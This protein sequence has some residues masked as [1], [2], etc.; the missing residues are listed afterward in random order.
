MIKK[1]TWTPVVLTMLVGIAIS[2]I[3]FL[4]LKKTN[5]RDL[6]QKFANASMERANVIIE[7]FDDYLRELNSIKR[8]YYGSDFVSRKE[9][10]AFVTPILQ[11][12]GFQAIEWLPRVSSEKRAHYE[13]A[14]Q[15]EG[16][17][18]FR[19]IE[20]NGNGQTKVAENKSLYFPVYY[21]EPLKGN[22]SA[23]GFAAD[24]SNP[25]FGSPI[26]KA[27]S[28]GKPSGGNRFLIKPDKEGNYVFNVVIPVYKG[29]KEPD[30]LSL[31]SAELEG[32]IQGTLKPA[33]IINEA[34]SKFHP[35]G[36]CTYF[37]DLA[38]PS[39]EQILY[40]HKPRIGSLNP[41]AGF[42][43]RF[44]KKF[45]LAGREYSIKCAPNEA[46]IY[47]NSNKEYL[48][49]PLLAF[50]F[51]ILISLYLSSVLFQREKA[52]ALVSKRNIEL[53]N[54][55]EK[56][57]LLIQNSND[58]IVII[59]QSGSQLFVS[60][61]AARITG[62]STDELRKKKIE[63][64][65]HPDDRARI[66]EAI[67]DCVKNPEKPVTVQ[68]RHKKKSGGYCY[69]ESVGM[70]F[71]NTPGIMGIVV[72]TRDITERK[73]VEDELRSAKEKA[74]EMNRLKTS[75]FANMSHEL[76][77]PLHGMLGIAQV[78]SEMAEDENKKNLANMIFSSGK[79]LL[80]TLN[81]ILNFSKVEANKQEIRYAKINLTE[82]VKHNISLFNMMALDKELSLDFYSSG[83]DILVYTDA[84]MIDSI[85]NNLIDNAI[86]YTER[87]GIKVYLEPE[88]VDGKSYAM[89]K[90]K[91]TGLGIPKNNQNNIFDEFQQ[92][93]QGYGRSFEG[94][95]LGLSIVKKYVEL[96]NGKILLTSKIGEGSEFTVFI[97]EKNYLEHPDEEIIDE[98]SFGKRLQIETKGR[99]LFV[100]DDIVTHNIVRLWLEKQADIEFAKDVEGAL[101]KLKDN[102]Y[103]LVILD[104]NLKKGGSGV[105]VMR[106]MKKMP[107][108]T[109]TPVI[110]CTAYAMAGE[111]EKLIAEGFK[112]YLSKPFDKAELIGIINSALNSKN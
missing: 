95:G 22:E 60:E 67:D 63:S 1:T 46:F 2:L 103:P 17:N 10:Q 72:N 83:K 94:T 85:L 47:N 108:Y 77:T 35:L 111:K 109:N 61:S 100:D 68:F 15:K 7:H 31:I 102:T 30:S 40:E 52:E 29:D 97:P 104:I 87:G 38:A 34:I 92:V 11:N 50:G 80:N 51:T 33:E 3:L 75:F 4:E 106:E 16:Y 43:Y 18:D 26:A 14:A 84:Q 98:T 86:K 64:V 105:D 41:A 70:N 107:V 89:I 24:L 59:D 57:R 81:M 27:Y 56:S 53:K 48:Y 45:E 90:I 58:V 42:N 19:F 93:S 44:I 5:D 32:F 20:V 39:N 69:L 13:S 65:V 91:D 21:L 78:L 110:A 36:I 23:L 6:E 28:S 99:I 82:A 25:V 12:K 55:E 71:I 88:I 79:R 112:Y 54:S 76:R 8:F 96:L 62:Y 49:L 37:S 74:E 66:L 9:F 73:L 101:E